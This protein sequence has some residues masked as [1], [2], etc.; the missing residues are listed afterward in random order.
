MHHLRH[1][2][3]DHMANAYTV[4]EPA[5]WRAL[6]ATGTAELLERYDDHL[7]EARPK[8][9]CLTNPGHSGPHDVI[10]P[11]ERDRSGLF[12]RM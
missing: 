6:V 9:C 7:A 1:W 12:I 11:S 5:R 10:D 8:L 3:L 4:R 2:H